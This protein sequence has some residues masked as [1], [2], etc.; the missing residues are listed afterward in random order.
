M[1][2]RK[3]KSKRSKYVPQYKGIDGRMKV[4]L[5]DN[6]GVEKE[7]DVADLIAKK[8]LPSWLRKEGELPKFKDGNP[9]NC[10]LANLYY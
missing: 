8:F 2:T 4:K 1:Y 7:E 9:E 10:A 6:F 5:I 3:I